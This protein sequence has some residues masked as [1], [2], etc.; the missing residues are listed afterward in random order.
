MRLVSRRILHST[1][2]NTDKVLMVEI[3]E[4]ER[5]YLVSVT[6][7]HRTAK[8]LNSQ[9]R[10]DF[11]READAVKMARKIAED[12][13]L[14]KD[15]YRDLP[16]G[17]TVKALQGMVVNNTVTLQNDV[18]KRPVINT[19]VLLEDIKPIRKIRL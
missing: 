10:H 4:I 14:G 6:W 3:Q 11:G 16:D 7:G 8:W 5:R 2:N 15:K 13:I 17:L 19:T 1:S 18:I 12:K 9:I